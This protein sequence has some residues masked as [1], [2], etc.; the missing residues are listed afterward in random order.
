MADLGKRHCLRKWAALP[1]VLLGLWQVPVAQ[2]ARPN[3]VLILADDLGFSDIA[4]YTSTARQ[5]PGH[6]T[7]G[8]APGC[9]AYVDIT[10]SLL[11]NQRHF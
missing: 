2:A 5:L 11:D 8:T 3:I 1:I 6:P 10:N 4:P 9:I 7:A